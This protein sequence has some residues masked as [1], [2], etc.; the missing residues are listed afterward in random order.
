MKVKT[1]VSMLFLYVL[2][3]SMMYSFIYGFFEDLFTTGWNSLDGLLYTFLTILTSQ[4]MAILLFGGI[5]IGGQVN[6]PE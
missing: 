4:L 5:Y 1:K 2:V 6:K 3:Y